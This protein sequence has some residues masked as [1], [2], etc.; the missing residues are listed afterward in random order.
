MYNFTFF[1]GG[2]APP[3]EGYPTDMIK[4]YKILLS[5][6]FRTTN[7]FN[8]NKAPLS[9]CSTAGA[10]GG[11]F[12]LMGPA[13][14]GGGVPRKLRET[15]HPPCSTAGGRKYLNTTFPLQYC[16]G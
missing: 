2:L 15:F 12:Q 11:A 4:V 13:P 3:L 14:E 9:S 5:Y 7:I 10:G 16:R 8:P 1:N 6:L